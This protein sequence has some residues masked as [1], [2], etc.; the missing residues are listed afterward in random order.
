MTTVDTLLY[1]AKVY[2]ADAN[3]SIQ[4]AIAINNGKIVAVGSDDDILRAFTAPNMLD[5][6]GAY[7]Y[8][9]LVDAHVHLQPYG[10]S[11]FEADLVGCTSY[12]D[13]VQRVEAFAKQHPAEATPRSKWV[14]GRGWDQ[15]LW[16]NKTMP[17]RELLDKYFPDRPVFLR[18]IDIHAAVVNSVALQM[19]GITPET[20]IDGGEIVVINGALTGLLV[21]EGQSPVRKLIPDASADDQ[22]SYIL[23]AA[24]TCY[25]YGLTGVGDAYLDVPQ[26]QFMW[27]LQQE[28]RLL[29]RVNGMIPANEANLDFFLSEKGLRQHPYRTTDSLRL[30]SF[31]LFADGALGSHG[32][33]LLEP[34]SDKPDTHGLALLEE[35]AMMATAKRLRRAG[36]QLCTHA[37]GDAA[38]RFVL[39]AYAKVLPQKNT[40]RWRVE[41]AQMVHPRDLPLFRA[42]GILPSVQPTHPTSD[43]KWLPERIGA[44]RLE[45]SCQLQ[46]L[47][48][49]QGKIALGSD[50]PVEGVNPLLGFYAAITRQNTVGE[51]AIGFLAHEKLSRQE[52]LRG[53]TIWNAYAEHAETIKGS[54]EEGKFADLTILDTDLLTC[55]PMAI[56]SA[57]VQYTF[58][59]REV[60]YRK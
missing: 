44:Q 56:L 30:E 29:L 52:A 48:Q 34:Y 36:K 51:P 59:G 49:Q 8:P 26:V 60:V 31:K 42:F 13:M 11:L 40:L 23:A 54:I 12:E 1:H 20:T 57:Q 7:I 17:T 15:N 22:K 58:I 19:A 14:L 25:R 46:T 5:L 2:T 33:W 21:D 28:K 4:E 24:E 27:E 6:H 50:F 3:F 9:G 39:Q 10:E 16:A 38:N 41:H 37:I 55:L 47:L 43:M 18:R 35:K 53:F 32:A 45:Y